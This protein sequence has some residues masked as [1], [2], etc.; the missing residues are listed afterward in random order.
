MIRYLRE[1]NVSL[2]K[3]H[4]ILGSI[5]GGVADLPFTKRSLR[6]ICSQIARDQ[7]DDDAKKTLEVFKKMRNDDP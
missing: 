2:S 6:T 4:C 7:M 3:V 1:N 5:F